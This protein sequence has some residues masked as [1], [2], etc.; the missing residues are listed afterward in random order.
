MD[1][2]KPT[3]L[4]IQAGIAFVGGC[5]LIIVA[6]G[7]FSKGTRLVLSNANEAHRYGR[8]SR[9]LHWATALLFLFMI[10]T[11][12]FASMIPEDAWY[13][14]EYNVVHKTIGL[15]IFG[16]VIARL[17]WNRRSK[18]LAL[19]ASLK[20]MERK[21]AHSAHV[22]LYALLIAIPVTGYVMTSHHGYPTFFFLIELPSFLP[23][24]QA[25]I[26]WGLFHKYVLQYLVYIILGAHIIGALKHRFIDKHDTAFKRM[27]S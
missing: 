23:E 12:I 26:V 21:L 11:G 8:V 1:A 18:R 4:W 16:L 9:V 5:A 22:L 17:V 14:T 19:D 13:R 3:L 10:P 24:S 6:A 27:V 7:Q 2:F 20:P 25:Y 15:I